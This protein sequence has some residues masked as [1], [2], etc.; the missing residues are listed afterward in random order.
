M[1]VRPPSYLLHD[2]FHQDLINKYGKQNEYT[3]ENGSGYYYWATK[4]KDIYYQGSCTI[5]CFPIFYS[6]VAKQSALPPTY[7]SL[8]KLMEESLIDY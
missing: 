2:F 3:H 1:F 6:E 7:K 4:N 5:T 8:G